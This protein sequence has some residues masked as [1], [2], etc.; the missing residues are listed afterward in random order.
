[1]TTKEYKNFKGLKKE[2]LRDNLSNMEL[3]LNM[4]GEVSITQISKKE[5]PKTFEENKKVAKKGGE[6]AGNTRKEIEN[7]TNDKLIM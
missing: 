2:N 1:M 7:K 5:N 3:V 6:I 4:L